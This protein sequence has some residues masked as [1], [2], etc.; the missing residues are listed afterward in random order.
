MSHS[1]AGHQPRQAGDYNQVKGEKG[2]SGLYQYPMHLLSTEELPK[3]KLAGL[4]NHQSGN[5][6]MGKILHFQSP[7]A[8]SHV[9]KKKATNKQILNI[10]RLKILFCGLLESRDPGG[11]TNYQR[12][13][14]W[15]CIC[16]D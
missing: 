9:L 12:K 13:L 16:Y 6:F 8:S 2:V 7:L 5:N 14:I 1:S 11:W 3:N 4:N 15:F 10:S